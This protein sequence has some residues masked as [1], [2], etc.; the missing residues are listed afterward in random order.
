MWITL[1]EA[2]VLT[3]LAGPE[4]AALKSA[5]TAAGQTNPLPEV[6]AQIV[7]EVRG[8]VA[9]GRQVELGVEG[10]IPDELLSA[11]LSRV[12]FELATRLPVASLLTDARRE[13]NRDAVTLLGRVS[14]AEF[15]VVPPP[16]DEASE[17][18]PIDALSG[19]Y[20]SAPKI[21]L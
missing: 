21:E 17:A 4:L 19:H 15:L 13:A 2:D 20:G 12:R 3:R 6:T 18:Q 8:Y 1:T 7:R 9:A 10:T 16:P 5:A 11:A 14:R